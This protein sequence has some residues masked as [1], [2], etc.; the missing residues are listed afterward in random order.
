M[1]P[2]KVRVYHCS[3]RSYIDTLFAMCNI[4][5]KVIGMIKS[6]SSIYIKF[7]KLQKK[8]H[9]ALLNVMSAACFSDMWKGPQGPEMVIATKT[10]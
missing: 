7:H 1:L 2:L 9:Y 10:A 5:R 3:I 8:T 6:A 4:S